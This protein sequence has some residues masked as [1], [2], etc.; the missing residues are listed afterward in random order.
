[1]QVSTQ[2]KQLT[3]KQRSA[4][5]ACFLGWTLDAFDF[6]II[7]FVLKDIAREFHTDITRVTFAI[8]VTL[9]MRPVGA[10][11][12]GLIADRYGRRP[13]LMINIVLY[14]LV[15][16]F[17]GWAP[18]LTVLIF[19]RGF[20][21]V[22]MGGEWGVGASLAMETI[23]PAARGAVSG[24]LQAGYPAGY[25]LAAILFN[26]SFHFLGWRGMFMVGVLPALLVLYVRQNVEESPVWSEGGSKTIQLWGTIKEHWGL[27]LYVI[28][29][30]T[31]FNSF[32]HG[33]QDI[34]PTFLQVQHGFPPA[35]VGLIAIVYNIGAILGGI[36]FGTFSERFGRRRS[37]VVAA[38]LTLPVLPLWAFSS[39]VPALM[40]GAFMMQFFM[41][42]AWGI[43]PVHLNELSPDG[44]RGSFPGFAYQLGNLFAAGNGTLQAHFAEM[45]G[46]N[47]G[48]SLALTVA[49]VAV[50]I[51][52]V[53]SLGPEFRG[54]KFGRS[55][56]GFPE[57]A[58]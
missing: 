21:G 9:A 45:N 27:F 55:A 26:T 44:V 12:F 10:L 40:I 46:R 37:I 41:Q 30:M 35:T 1:M 25:L 38:L 28:V 29:L 7:V 34:Y 58:S 48:L 47:Y 43:I 5:L 36:F 19:L 24:V 20:Y 17:S 23:P 13:T 22:A 42:G 53:T 33:T 31:V 51:V 32:S 3:P 14:S 11:V 18:N 54:V 8:F 4:V 50:L 52:V 56:Q 57:P 6:F 49:I 16:F 2:L 39:T 15:E